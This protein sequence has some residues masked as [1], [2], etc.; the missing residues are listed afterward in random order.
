MNPSFLSLS[1][2]PLLKTLYNG[3]YSN[4]ACSATPVLYSKSLPVKY[5]CLSNS[6]DDNADL[7]A[8]S[9]S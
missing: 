7:L 5:S 8:V 6:F 2:N 4:L 1:F 9:L 3:E